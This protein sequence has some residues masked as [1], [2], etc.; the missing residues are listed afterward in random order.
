M[1]LVFCA[2]FFVG[3]A[4]SPNLVRTYYQLNVSE[5]TVDQHLKILATTDGVRQVTPAHDSSN[6]VTLQVYLDSED[7]FDG[8]EKLRELGY[9]RVRD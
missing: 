1:P 5:E 4:R 8:Q 3:C 2:L 7:P 9:T 6:K